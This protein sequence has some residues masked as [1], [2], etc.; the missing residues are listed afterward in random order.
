MLILIVGY[1]CYSTITQ[2]ARLVSITQKQE[3]QKSG[4]S[5]KA[6]NENLLHK[7]DN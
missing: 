3:L 5:S 2:L 1:V 4:I 7:P 6:I